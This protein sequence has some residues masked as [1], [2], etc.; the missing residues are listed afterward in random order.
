MSSAQNIWVCSC[1]VMV[2]ALDYRIGLHKFK[3]QSCYYILFRTNTLE[4]DMN[5][6]ILPA[7]G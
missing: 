7:M 5:P 3:L 6:L 4:K 2:K 1:G